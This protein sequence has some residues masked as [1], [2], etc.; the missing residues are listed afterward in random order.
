MVANGVTKRILV[1]EDEALIAMNLE[2]ALTDLGHEV[3]GIAGRMDDALALAREVELDFAVLDITIAD[4]RSF[5]I[6]D[7][8]QERG[9]PF[10]FASGY[11]SE[12][13][14]DG[15]KDASVLRKPYDAKELE[16]IIAKLPPGR[17][18]CII[19]A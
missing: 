13:L 5:A 6:A 19:K 9:I 10:V 17:K 16:C 15:Y 1:V 12:G 2:D 18:N 8:L 3:V 11:G 7:V 4:G 14:A